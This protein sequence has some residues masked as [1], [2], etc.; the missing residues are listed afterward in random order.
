MSRIKAT[1]ADL[2]REGRPGLIAYVTCGFPSPASTTEIVQAMA[3]A[4]A[5]VVELGVPFSDPL[6]DGR[7]IQKSN[8]AALSQG[9]SLDGCIDQVATLRGSGLQTPLVLMG[10]YNPILA[11][12]EQTFTQRAAAAGLDGVIVVDLPTEEAGGFRAMC[13]AHG[14]DLIFLIA[15]TTSD[16]RIRRASEAGSGFLY[17][18]SLTGTTGVRERLPAG[19][20][21]F[22]ERVRALT[23]LPLAVGFG[24]STSDQFAAVGELADAVV[25]GSAIIDVI[26]RADESM[27]C[28]KLR[29]Y[30]EVVSGRRKPNTSA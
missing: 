13:V 24:I 27:R 14:L 1:F 26:D 29:E 3:T 4:G 17:C 9:V 12:G 10:Y 2:K 25:I 7:T 30:L 16:E 11:M 21:N 23:K 22:I 19:L 8:Q 20:P 15:P 6:A 28:E 5:D 18:V